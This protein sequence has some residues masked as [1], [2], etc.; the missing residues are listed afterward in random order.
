MRN[1]GYRTASASFGTN[2]NSITVMLIDVSAPPRPDL[3]IDKKRLKVLL[4][5]RN[6]SVWKP[7]WKIR[8]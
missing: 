4:Q 7:I 6:A 1:I 3:A 5:S 2:T 8:P